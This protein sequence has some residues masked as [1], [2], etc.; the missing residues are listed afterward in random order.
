MTVEDSE[1]RQMEWDAKTTFVMCT[2]KAEGG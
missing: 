1:E 2:E